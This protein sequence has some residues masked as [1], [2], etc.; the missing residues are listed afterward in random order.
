M[1]ELNCYHFN[2]QWEKGV[3]GSLVKGN[4]KAM[5]LTK[6]FLPHIN[7]VFYSNCIKHVTNHTSFASLCTLLIM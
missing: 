3:Q 5:I 6:L 4:L 7:F 1:S 2:D